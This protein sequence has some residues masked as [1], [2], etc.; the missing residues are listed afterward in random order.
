VT[1]RRPCVAIDGPV[2]AGKSTVARLAAQR[3]GYTYVDS[4]AMYRALAWAARQRGIAADEVDRTCGL[5]EEVEIR[6]MPEANGGNRVLVNGADVTDQIRALE[7]GELASRL[8][9]IPAVREQM[10]ALQQAMA[11]EGGVVMEG[12]DI[13]TVVL[14]EAE[15]KIFLT[16]PAEE[17]AR[18]RH[19][20]LR[21][22]GFKASFD[23][24]LAQ[25]RARDDRDSNRE[26]SP[27]RAAPDAVSIDTGGL[28]VDQV[29][30]EVLAAVRARR[31]ASEPERGSPSHA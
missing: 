27:L 1:A 15:V 29:V 10:V 22:R 2:A 11:R 12:R 17:R 9:E 25:V 18:R 16:A 30:G 3:L 6:L 4:G 21:D 13:Q 20:E 26:H 23:K 5:L 8:S 31:T 24:V 7:I 19:L 14:P 28:T